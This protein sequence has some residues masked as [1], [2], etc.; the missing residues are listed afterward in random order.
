MSFRRDGKSAHEDK[1]S[2]DAWKAA[3]ADLLRACGLPPG[4]LRGWRD[5]NYLMKYGHWCEHY[6]GAHIGKI[7]FDLSEL[8][9]EQKAVFRQLLERT[10][11][12]D[13]K[14]QGCAAWHYV[15]PPVP[16]A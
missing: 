14:K 2:W 15:C 5:W 7:D 9:A 6:Y 1:R 12:D 8:N 16:P 3:N 4:I 13:E 11:D 10:L